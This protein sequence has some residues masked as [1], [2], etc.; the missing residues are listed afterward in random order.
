MRKRCAA[1]IGGLVA[2]RRS[3]L[4]LYSIPGYIEDGQSWSSILDSLV[5]VMTWQDWIGPA[6]GFACFFYALSI[7]TW[8]RKLKNLF[9]RRTAPVPSS[10]IPA[11]V[12]F[13]VPR[14]ASPPPETSPAILTPDDPIPAAP[15]AK[16]WITK[17]GA[18]QLIRSSSLVRLRLPKETVT[19]TEV[20][21]RALGFGSETPGEKLAE[22]L[23]HKLVRDFTTQ[24]PA[25]VRDGQY[26]REHLEWCIEEESYRQ[27]PPTKYSEKR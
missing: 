12:D 1:F 20:I 22:E 27:Q 4:H 21:A 15:D 2:S 11:N 16:R 17:N 13:Q 25:W 8:P 24:Y 19:G 18:L 6:I 10:R 3:L 26:C 7:H 5:A 9:I 23:A 14:P